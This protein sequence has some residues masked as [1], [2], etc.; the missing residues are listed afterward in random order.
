MNSAAGV[1]LARTEPEQ[2]E[3]SGG[4]SDARVVSDTSLRE[5]ITYVL[6]LVFVCAAAA[7]YVLIFLWG[8]GKLKFPDS[9]AHWLGAATIG[10][11][12]SLLVI[13]VKS[14]FPGSGSTGNPGNKN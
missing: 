4:V 2:L 7:S 10:Q 1:D 11:T 3:P 9:F 8:A 5:S 14:L 12:A 13:I 6:L